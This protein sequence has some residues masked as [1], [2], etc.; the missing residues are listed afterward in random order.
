MFT[1]GAGVFALDLVTRRTGLLRAGAASVSTSGVGSTG[2]RV[3][4]AASVDG[5]SPVLLRVGTMVG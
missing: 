5:A 4:S 3:E 2:V 1:S